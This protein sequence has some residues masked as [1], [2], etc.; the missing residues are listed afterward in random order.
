M[1]NELTCKNAYAQFK[2]EFGYDQ[3]F[4][5][6]IESEA[7]IDNTSGAHIQF[8]TVIV[9]YLYHLIDIQSDIKIKNAST[10]SIE[11]LYLQIKN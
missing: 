9:P 1:K 10:S 3:D 2:K 8:G 4:F 5:A 6:K 7:G 11:C